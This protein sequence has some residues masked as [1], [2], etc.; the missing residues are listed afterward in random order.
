MASHLIRKGEVDAPRLLT[1]SYV[2]RGSSDLRFIQEVEA[3]CHIEGMHLSTQDA[4]MF[5]HLQPAGITPLDH[6]PLQHAAATLARRHGAGTFLTG[7]GGDLLLGNWIDDSL[8]VSAPLRRGQLRRAMSDAFAWS[9]ATKLPVPYI[10]ARAAAAALP[11]FSLRRRL[12]RNRLLNQ[13]TIETSLDA[14]FCRRVGV[15]CDDLDLTA[16]WLRAPVERRHHFRALA[17]TTEH[18]LLQPLEWMNGLAYTHPLFD[19]SLV[20]FVMTIPAEVLCGAGE[21]RRLMRRALSGLWPA[22]LRRRRSKGL[23]TAPYFEAF[24]KFAVTLLSTKR[25]HSAER[26]WVDGASLASRLERFSRG[27]DCNQMQLRRILLLE[28]WLQQRAQQGFP[29]G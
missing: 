24:R 6:C 27:L 12:G 23:F 17:L 9:R 7:Q 14:T 5:D 19:R 20:E 10:L 21:P 13:L 18:R 4:P 11:T 16:D 1:V 26:G 15:P 25:W 29:A 22:G 8:Q 3:D 28:H 2:N